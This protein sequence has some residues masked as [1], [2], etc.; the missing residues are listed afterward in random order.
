MGALR[1]SESVAKEAGFNTMILTSQ[2][3]GEA[4]VIAKTIMGIAKEVQDF[5]PP[6]FS[7]CCINHGRRNKCK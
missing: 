4:K 1:A 6:D 5:P 2:N 7:T 3:H